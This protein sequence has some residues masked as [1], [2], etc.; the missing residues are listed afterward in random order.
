MWKFSH[1]REHSA[2]QPD[3]LYFGGGAAGMQLLPV[4]VSMLLPYSREFGGLVS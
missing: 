4:A 2:I 1:N 3:N